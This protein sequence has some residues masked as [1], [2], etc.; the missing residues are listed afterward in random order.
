MH[1]NTYNPHNDLSNFVLCYW[2]LK[3]EKGSTPKKNTIIPDGTMKLIFHFGDLYKHHPK[4]E[5][6]YS[7]P[8]CFLIGQLTE[9]YIV[10]PMGETGTFIVRFHPNGFLPFTSISIKESENKAI[11]LEKLYGQEGVS[12]GTSVIGAVNNKE[13][14]EI[15]ESFLL[16][17]LKNSENID[18]VVQRTVDNIL[19]ASGQVN[20]AELSKD[21]KLNRRSLARKFSSNVGL[22][23]KQLSKIIRLQT[24][25]NSLLNSE[26]DKLT[27]VVY[28]NQFF[29]QAHFIKD[30]KEFT[31]LTP[32]EFYGD[33]FKM[34][35]IF[36][37]KN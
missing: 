31:G 2:S 24:S 29:D 9:P 36:D 30:F 27:D 20:I 22:S 37:S 32:K 17:K 15:I 8:R 33:D 23:P 26:I 4:N 28:E 7:L 11:S 34:S 12:L 5:R 16:G 35:L 19:K 6:S 10:E 21:H 1:P 25:L 13:R 3:S 18:R 14:I